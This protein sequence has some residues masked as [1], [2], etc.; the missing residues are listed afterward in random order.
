MIVWFMSVLLI[1]CA[2]ENRS[3]N[4]KDLDDIILIEEAV[5]AAEAV[6]DYESSP[7]FNE[8]LIN[9][10]L[11]D[12]YDLVALHSEHPEFMDEVSSQLKNFTNDSISNYKTTDFAV[13]KN[14]R[15]LG[16]TV[17]VNDSIQKVKLAYDKVVGST[18]T[19]DTIYAII[20]KKMVTL[21]EEIL[22]SN[23]VQFSK[24]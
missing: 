20:T 18:K 24:N 5:E 8:E 10:K 9:Q 2:M 4:S 1:N 12:F 14:V 6:A 22:I 7:T 16:K 23:K 11:Q 13:V 17:F 3:P 15:Q 21:D 19:R